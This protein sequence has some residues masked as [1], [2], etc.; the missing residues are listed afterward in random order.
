MRG[1][2]ER[3]DDTLEGERGRTL[4]ADR[5]SRQIDQP[6]FPSGSPH[7]NPRAAEC[8]ATP[9]RLGI[10]GVSQRENSL[11][12]A[13]RAVG[14]AGWEHV[15][16][17]DAPRGHPGSLRSAGLHHSRCPLPASKGCGF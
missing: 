16:F 4:T 12:A 15:P 14:R 13:G 10:G 8:A 3:A 2:D 5:R 9:L 1:P 11:G 7:P 6:S 17:L